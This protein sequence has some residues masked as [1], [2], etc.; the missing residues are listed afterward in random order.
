MPDGADGADGS[1]GAT[2]ATGPAGAIGPQ[3]PIGPTGATGAT[4]PAGSLNVN[5]ANTDTSGTTTSAAYTATLTGGGTNPATT[6]TVPASGNVLITLTGRHAVG[7]QP[8]G[9]H[10][11]RGVRCEHGRRDRR[12]LAGPR[13][14]QQRRDRVRAGQRDL[15]ADRP[16]RRIHD[17]HVQ[18]H[19]T[20]V[21][22]TAAFANRSII[23]IPLP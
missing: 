17:V 15:P 1:A 13:A 14:R 16:D 23:A 6:I 22:N 21:G 7:V 4:G 3:G 10:G 19:S 9:V 20:G 2:G 5:S 18:Y 8:V 11:L 12:P